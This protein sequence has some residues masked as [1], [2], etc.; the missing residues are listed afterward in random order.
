MYFTFNKDADQ[1]ALMRRLLCIRFFARS[2]I[3]FTRNESHPNRDC[4][5]RHANDVLSGADPGFQQR[6]VHVGNS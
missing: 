5:T 2:N 6:E 3:S 1:I 4:I